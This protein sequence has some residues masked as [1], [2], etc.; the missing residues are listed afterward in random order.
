[1]QVQV[2]ILTPSRAPVDQRLAGLQRGAERA[3]KALP[4]LWEPL[5]QH[6]PAPF[7]NDGRQRWEVPRRHLE[8]GGC[9]SDRQHSGRLEPAGPAAVDHP[10]LLRRR[11][12]ISPGAL[13]RAAGDDEAPDPHARAAQPRSRRWRFTPWCGPRRSRSSRAAA[14][15]SHCVRSPLHGRGLPPSSL[16]WGR[17]WVKVGGLLRWPA[18]AGDLAEGAG[19]EPAGGC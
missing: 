7:G 9:P 1:M 14:S 15:A 12:A 16:G 2:P 17:W 19:F 8:P 5:C 4:N 6:Q 18:F 11:S 10:R 3:L 13:A